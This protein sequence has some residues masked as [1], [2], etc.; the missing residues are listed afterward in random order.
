MQKAH[1]SIWLDD[2]FNAIS[3][4]TYML[5]VLLASAFLTNWFP[6]GDFSFGTVEWYHAVMI[7][8][9]FFLMIVAAAAVGL[10]DKIRAALNLSTYPVIATTLL[11]IAFVGSPVG[12]VAEGVRDAW[13]MFLAV[14]FDVALLVFPFKER[15]RFKQV[16]GAYV[17]LF[18][19]SVSATL[20]GL[21]GLLVAQGMFV[22]YSSMPFLQSYINGLGINATTFEGNLVTSHSHEMLPAV[23]GGIVALTALLVHYEKLDPGKRKLVNAGM[24]VS[25]FGV[26]SMSYLYFISGL[27]T[28]S[29][30][31]I[32]PFGPG[33]MNGLALDDSQTG[34]VGWGALISLVGLWPFVKRSSVRIASVLTWLFAMLALIGIGYYIEFN[35]SYYGFG[36]PG[37]P[38]NGGPGYA[39]DDAFMSGHLMYPFF[40]LPLLAAVTIYLDWKLPEGSRARSLVYWLSLSGMVLGLIGLGVF[41]ITLVPYVEAAGIVLMGVAMAVGLA[42]LYGQKLR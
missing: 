29:I 22:G 12:T 3:L 7:P 34:I 1:G 4:I 24:L 13:V 41:L 2:R 28:Y 17:L 21:Y 20:A 40:F 11:G 39:H 32:A 10:E 8:F 15:E 36:S 42:G 38:P 33:G 27:G 35:E 30:P 16:F 9:T 25:T 26:I 5:L 37:V 6:L 23:M 19:A 31:A 18:V 14:I